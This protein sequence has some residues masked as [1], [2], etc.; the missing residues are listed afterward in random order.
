[1]N[2][3]P[4]NE[5]LLDD[6]LA[7]ESGVPVREVMLA[8]MLKAVQRQRRVRQIRKAAP[9][10]ALCLVLLFTVW[11]FA[12]PRPKIFPSPAKSYTLVTT[13]PLDAVVGT[14]PFSN[15]VTSSHT[16][17]AI[18]TSVASDEIRELNDDQLLELAAPSSVI[19]V[20]HGPHLAY[21]IFAEPSD[22]EVFPGNY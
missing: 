6:V 7:E 16:V 18:S 15:I 13:Q 21:L 8:E 1:M 9:A 2:D 17:E 14:I 12:T 20:R 11:R 4:N 5:G 10:V 19:L 22:Q 3:F